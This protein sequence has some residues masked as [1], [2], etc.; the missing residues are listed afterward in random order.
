MMKA[1]RLGGR[2]AGK[3][4]SQEALILDA[5]YWMQGWWMLDSARQRSHSLYMNL[6]F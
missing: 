5:G 2:E 4:G 3:L 1:G 6:I